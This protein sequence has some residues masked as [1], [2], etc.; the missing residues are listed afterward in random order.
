[1]SAQIVVKLKFLTAECVHQAMKA[2]FDI[3]NKSVFLA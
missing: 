2:A 3:H 1:M